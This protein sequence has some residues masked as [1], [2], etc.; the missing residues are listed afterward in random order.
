MSHQRVLALLVAMLVA[1]VMTASIRAQACAQSIARVDLTPFDRAGGPGLVRV[2]ASATCSWTVTADDAWITFPKG[3]SGTGTA[4]VPFEVAAVPAGTTVFRSGTVRVASSSD[5]IVQNTSWMSGTVESPTPSRVVPPF[6]MSGWSLRDTGSGSDTDAVEVGIRLADQTNSAA[7]FPSIINEA[8][9]HVADR[10]GSVYRNT[11]WSLE[12]ASLAPGN[13]IYGARG[14]QANSI[15]WF[16]GTGSFTV[17]APFLTTNVTQVPM[18]IV[19][20]ATGVT[21]MT[22]AQPV[23][24]SGVPRSSAW[25]AVPAQPWIVVTPGA[26][27]GEGRFSVSI[28]TAQ[29]PVTAGGTL[30]G[31]V[32]V[33]A[34]GVPGGDLNLPVIVSVH[35]AGAT[36][37]AFG[38]FDTP[39]DNATGLN[40]AVAL[41][42]WAL[43]DV[44]VTRVQIYRAPVAAEPQTSLVFIGDAPLVEGARP[45][46]AALNP[47]YPSATRAGWGYLLLSNVLPG[48]GT[49]QFTFYVYA[50]DAEGRLTLLGGRTVTMANDAATAPFGTLDTPAQGEVISGEYVVRGWVLT[51]QPATVRPD[52]STVAVIID[53]QYVGRPVLGQ[54]RPDVGALFPSLNNATIAGGTYRL[55]T[56]R[57]TNGVHTIAWT[58]FDNMGR[59]A[60]IGSRYFIVNNP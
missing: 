25:T 51:P 35:S 26:G 33:Q 41:T 31:N 55:D 34:P 24:V 48:Q 30:T 59:V 7:Y 57:L 56:R 14:H 43:D 9:E 10:Y 32:R 60:G 1:G 38:A 45:D 13:Y 18:A 52:G 6:T 22:P 12:F 4:L 11:G 49:G 15:W 8:R 47:D 42:G 19:R 46:V 28:D 3:A 54:S 27:S 2:T 36:A 39:A 29:L 40:G 50:E 23:I 53:G 21:A 20:S 44:G 17:V 37:P 16:I 58:L 5:T